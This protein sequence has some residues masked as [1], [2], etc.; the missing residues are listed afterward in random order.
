[1]GCVSAGKSE[2]NGTSSKFVAFRDTV[3]SQ[4]ESV[5]IGEI[6]GNHALGSY[7]VKAHEQDWTHAPSSSSI[8]SSLAS[9]QLSGRNYTLEFAEELNSSV[10]CQEDVLQYVKELGKD[11]LCLFGITKAAIDGSPTIEDEFDE[12]EVVFSAMP[13][14][15]ELLER[16]ATWS[17]G[18]AC[19][20]AKKPHQPNQDNM[21]MCESN[22]LTALGVADGHGQHGHWASHFVVQFVV[23]LLFRDVLSEGELPTDGQIMELFEIA[24]EALAMRFSEVGL[25]L[26]E[27][28]TTLTICIVDHCKSTV[29][30]AWVG[31]SRCVHCSQIGCSSLTKD[32]KPQDLSEKTRIL[33]QGGQIVGNRVRTSCVSKSTDS[34]VSTV[35][36]LAMS[37]SIGD[38]S[39]QSIGVSHFPMVKRTVLANGEDAPLGEQVILCCSDGIWDCVSN[40]EAADIIKK[41]LPGNL[42]EG[43]QAL[44]NE[45]RERWLERDSVTD[46]ISCLALLLGCATA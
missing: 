35:A 37:R 18:V 7:P 5:K 19:I 43:V 10:K 28:G 1:M 38:T 40:D 15:E 46:D 22:G 33:A 14:K 29:L 44:V 25:S 42:N 32:H 11:D 26:E 27:S 41:Y 8:M 24:H 6:N 31:D 17:A 20:K 21:F 16:L 9:G 12:K 23:Y 30:T 3:T 36:E 4:D 13:G 34:T 2:G 45:S 39:F